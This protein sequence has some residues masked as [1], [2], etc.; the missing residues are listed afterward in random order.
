MSEFVLTTCGKRDRV[1]L[2]ATQ[3]LKFTEANHIYVE[4]Q[5][6]IN[7]VEYRYSTHLYRTPNGTWVTDSVRKGQSNNWND[8]YFSRVGVAFSTNDDISSNARNKGLREIP[9]LLSEAIAKVESD[10]LNVFRA[11]AEVDYIQGRIDSVSSDLEEK[12]KEIA[13]LEANLAAYNKR[14]DDANNGVLPNSY[15]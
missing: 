14:L 9:A 4:G 7:G 12:R 15:A 1:N 3:K 11:E 2:G 5:V 10:K 13:A 8:I 6:D